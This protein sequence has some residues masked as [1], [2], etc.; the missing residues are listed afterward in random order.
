MRGFDEQ[1]LRE[2]D[3]ACRLRFDMFFQRCFLLLNPGAIFQENWSLDAMVHFAEKVI[4]GE[5]TRGIVNMPPR[6]GKSLLFNVALCAFILGHDPRKRIFCISHAGT[7]S[8]DHANMFRAIVESAFY[9]RIFP[10]MKIKRVVDDEVYTTKRGYRRWTSVLGSMVGMGGDLFIVDDPIKP[11]DAQSQVKRDNVNQWFS[12]TLLTR[13]DSKKLG[14]ILI[15]MQRLHQDDLSGFLLRNAG[16]WEHLNLPAI[17]ELPQTVELRRGRSYR[18]EVGDILHPERE[19]RDDLERQ[20]RDMGSALFSAHYL[21]RPVPL[22]GSMMPSEWIQFYDVL[23]ERDSSSIIF[24]SWDT[25]AKQGLLNSYSCCM[26]FLYHQK[27]YYLLDV[28]RKR[29]T[30]PELVAAAEALARK[31]KPR[32]IIIEDASSG[33]ALAQTLKTPSI[34]RLIKPEGDKE[35]RFYVQQQKFERSDV[36]FPRIAPWLRILLEEILAFPHGTHSDQVDSLSQALAFN[37]ATGYSKESMEGLRS[38][39]NDF[40]FSRRLC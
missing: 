28:F 23:P 37:L 22:D 21:Q 8:S 26:T 35:V 16:D 17:A 38:F 11:V 15:V 30:F 20:R 12:N 4:A 36:L 3:A 25:A 9:K 24:Q 13:L 31:H 40:Y 5:I 18:R 29:V 34:I 6:Y 1:A 27:K 39:M 14:S 32:F 33:P 7:L 10:R 2:Y 19:N